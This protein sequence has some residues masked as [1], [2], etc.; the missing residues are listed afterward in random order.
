MNA[1]A[2]SGDETRISRDDGIAAGA[3]IGHEGAPQLV[4]QIGGDLGG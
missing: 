2:S 3:E 4:E 1:A